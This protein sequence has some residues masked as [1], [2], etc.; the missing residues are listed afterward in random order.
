MAETSTSTFM[1]GRAN[2]GR[3]AVTTT[4]AVFVTRMAVGETATPIR[5]SMFAR[6]CAEKMV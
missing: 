4:A 3:V 5:S 1:P 6:L 2:G